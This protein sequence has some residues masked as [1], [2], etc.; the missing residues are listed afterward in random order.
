MV[1][2][3]RT[4][5][6]DGTF[7]AGT[8]LPS[9]AQLVE[10]F[11]V[12]RGTVRQALTILV[13]EKLIERVNGSGTFVR[14]PVTSVKPASAT[15]GEPQIGVILNRLNAQLSTEMLLGIERAVRAAGYR[16]QLTY[17]SDRVDQ[18]SSELTRLHE[19]GTDGVILFPT[20]SDSKS[21]PP[22]DI[23]QSLLS[24]GAPVVL[25]DRYFPD[26]DTD[27]VTADNFE[28]GFRATEHLIMMGYEQIGFYCFNNPEITSIRDRYRGYRQAL[29]HYGLPFT[30]DLF[31]HVGQH[32]SRREDWEAHLTA[33]PLPRAIFACDDPLALLLLKIAHRRQLSV[34]DDLALVGFDNQDF[35]A[36]VMPPLTT[37][38]QPWRD[39]G[40]HAAHLLLDRLKAPH[41]PTEHLQLPTQLVVRESCGVRQHLQRLRHKQ[42]P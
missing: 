35:T 4:Y 18:L 2:Y 15:T 21:L 8:R 32:S 3:L 10:E 6:L 1:A 16:L 30:D 17:I 24:R 7:P 23:V 9:E 5:I 25:V 12:S 28:G 26:L 36:D 40:Y 14:Q 11:G 39:I 31:C 37:L 27:Y 13:N 22:K 38:K 34:P 20:E 42:N 19:S 41:K 33:R 29:A